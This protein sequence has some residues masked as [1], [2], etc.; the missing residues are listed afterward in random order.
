MKLFALKS[1]L[2]VEGLEAFPVRSLAKSFAYFYNKPRLAALSLPFA[3]AI[4][5]G[6]NR[7][8][9][10]QGVH[11]AFAKTKPKPNKLLSE[12]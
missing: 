5:F 8:W 7:F 9:L 11:R 10:L 3:S 12:I 1:E 4:I 2:I 6:Q